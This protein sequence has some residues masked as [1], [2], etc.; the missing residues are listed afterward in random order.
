[1]AHP[2]APA[3][4]ETAHRPG[5]T[6]ADPTGCFVCI[7]R[8]FGEKNHGSRVHFHRCGLHLHM[9]SFRTSGGISRPP[10]SLRGRVWVR[11][12]RERPL[13]SRPPLRPRPLL[14]VLSS[15]SHLFERLP[16]LWISELSQPRIRIRR[17]PL[18]LPG[19]PDRAHLDRNRIRAGLRWI[20]AIRRIWRIRRIWVPRLRAGMVSRLRGPRGNDL[21][22]RGESLRDESL[23][24]ESLR[25]V[26]L[27]GQSRSDRSP[28]AVGAR[29]GGCPAAAG[30]FAA[31]GQRR[32]G[33][34]SPRC[35]P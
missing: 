13:R 7:S 25:G 24:D 23:C 32:F 11:Y 1:M 10:C 30:C 3:F 20:G 14:W 31:A 26:P 22:C 5:I 4:R 33:A 9:G 17:Q 19:I 18:R 8:Y 29:S 6:I 35:S 15:D 16:W 27:C 12:T 34:A 21:F 28:L 2:Q